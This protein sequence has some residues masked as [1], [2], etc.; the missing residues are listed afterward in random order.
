MFG[1]TVK[2]DAGTYPPQWYLPLPYLKTETL[3]QLALANKDS[4]STT[5]LQKQLDF[6]LT[7]RKEKFRLRRTRVLL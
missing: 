7:K 2:Q 3:V 6:K 5:E 1:V 4:P